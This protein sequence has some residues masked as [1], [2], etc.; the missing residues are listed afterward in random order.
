MPVV[1]L[2]QTE[3][4][5]ELFKTT[6]LLHTLDLHLDIDIN[7]LPGYSNVYLEYIPL[8]NLK[9]FEFFCGYSD[10]QNTVK[11]CGFWVDKLDI[12]NL[13]NISIH[14]RILYPY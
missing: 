5:L 6:P 2:D 11:C 12:P 4:L 1:E 10:F 3:E 8:H 7:E 13:E 9:S 14:L